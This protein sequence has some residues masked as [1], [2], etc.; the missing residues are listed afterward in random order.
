MVFFPKGVE[1]TVDS[2]SVGWS[3]DGSPGQCRV[4]APYPANWSPSWH[5]SGV[6]QIGG[7][8]SGGSTIDSGMVVQGLNGCLAHLKVNGE[9]GQHMM[10]LIK[11]T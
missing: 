2:C 8:A 4:F 7:T 11:E 6:L 9:V 10:I 1:L 3:G 5:G